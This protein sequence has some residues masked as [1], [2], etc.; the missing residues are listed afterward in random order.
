[1]LLTA[2]QRPWR[3]TCSR[4]AP[5]SRA[6]STADGDA[7]SASLASSPLLDRRGKALL[8]GDGLFKLVDLARHL[9][10]SP[11]GRATPFVMPLLAR[12]STL[13]SEPAAHRGA[14][15]AWCSQRTNRR[16][17]WVPSS[18]RCSAL[19]PAAPFG[20]LSDV[21]HLRSVPA[22]TQSTS[23]RASGGAQVVHLLPGARHDVSGHREMGEVRDMAASPHYAGTQVGA[24]GT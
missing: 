11:F 16:L 21:V 2:A 24:S 4:V 12:R 3:W 17:G 5:A 10:S 19:R 6:R 20:H 15:A 13:P 22:V 8:F 23:H 7:A 14:R 9:G 18:Q 1:M